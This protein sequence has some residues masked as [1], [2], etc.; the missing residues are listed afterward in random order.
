MSTSVPYEQL[1]LRMRNCLHLDLWNGWSDGEAVR[2]WSELWLVLDGGARVEL[3]DREY[4]VQKGDFCLLPDVLQKFH[5]CDLAPRFE[6]YAIRFD[7][8][9][10]NGSLFEQ[11]QCDTWVTHLSSPLFEEVR[12]LFERLKI[13]NVYQISL[14][15]TL[16]INRDLYALMEL[17]FSLVTVTETQRTDW[18]STTLQYMATH[19][20]E[21]LSIELLAKRAAMHPK[22]FSR[23]FREKMGIAPG[24]YLAKIRLKKASDLLKKE[25]PL[26]E[27]AESIGFQ[28]VQQFFRFFKKQTGLTPREYQRKYA[29][30]GNV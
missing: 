23:K 7:S 28:S 30:G 22:H 20:D 21:K 5:T 13:I 19:A 1:Q 11:I 17:F 10:L 16:Q 8:S 14:K 15:R 25:M 18:L 6:L 29:R 2:S 12:A 3:G 24:R 27:I 4:R 9:L 26:E